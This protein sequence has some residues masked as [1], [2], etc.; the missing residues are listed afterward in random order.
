MSYCDFALRLTGYGKLLGNKPSRVLGRI[1]GGSFTQKLSRCATESQS[2]AHAARA[3]HRRCGA[4]GTLPWIGDDHPI[5]DAVAMLL[6]ADA[7]IE[8]AA[9]QRGLDPALCERRPRQTSRAIG[10]KAP[11]QGFNRSRTEPLASCRASTAC[12]A[13]ISAKASPRPFFLASS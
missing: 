11:Y 8:A 5:C 3:P 9:R 12:A 13:T 1:T 4:A 10:V 7:A 6:P 2:P